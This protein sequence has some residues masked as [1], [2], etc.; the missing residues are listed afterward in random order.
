MMDTKALGNRNSAAMTK[1]NILVVDDQARWL[2]CHGS[3][4]SLRISTIF[5]K[6]AAARKHWR[7]AA[8]LMILP[9]FLLDV[10]MPGMDGFENR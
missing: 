3:C 8:Y 6:P 1:T 4:A 7:Y 2:A 5:L 9:S 10:Q